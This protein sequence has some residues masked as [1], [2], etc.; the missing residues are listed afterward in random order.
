MS[1]VFAIWGIFCK[2]KLIS[3]RVERAKTEA[4][5]FGVPV[6]QLSAENQRM[7]VSTTFGGYLS[8][9]PKKSLGRDFPKARQKRQATSSPA[10]TLA[11]V[12]QYLNLKAQ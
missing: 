3:G 9:S 8:E 12:G 2:A 1:Q 6:C 4:R 11:E 7:L 5:I 10:L